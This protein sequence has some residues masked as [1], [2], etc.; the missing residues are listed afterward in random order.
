MSQLCSL[1]LSL[2][3]PVITERDWKDRAIGSASIA[4]D[5]ALSVAEAF[6]PLKAALATV[7]TVYGQYK[8]RS[9]PPVETFFLKVHFQETAAVVG[10]I[11]VLSSRIT[12][13]EKIFEQPTSDEAEKRRRKELLR[14]VVC[15][16]S[17]RVLRPL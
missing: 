2:P 9:L 17:G 8:V 7:S 10:K 3:P 11:E 14:C 12:F 4:L 15:L 1:V 6:S 16:C 5:I 13:L